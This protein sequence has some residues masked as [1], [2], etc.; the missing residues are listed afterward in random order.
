MRRK[1]GPNLYIPSRKGIKPHYRG[2]SPPSF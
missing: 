2:Y 1:E